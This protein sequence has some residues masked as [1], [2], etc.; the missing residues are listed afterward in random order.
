MK[1]TIADMKVDDLPEVIELWNATE[2]V[3]LN[4]SDTP[5]RLA[6]YLSRNPQQSFIARDSKT[7]RIV[8]AVLCG[9][10]GRRGYLHHLAVAA[11]S[12]GRGIGSELVRKCFA[13]LAAAGITRCNLYVY[14]S[15]ND[16]REFWEKLGW[17]EREDLAVMQIAVNVGL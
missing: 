9:N 13:A 3:G 11:D 8:G 10:D 2:G 5:E 17:A 16:G 6:Q 15:N 14:R 4:E 7:G 1:T 12:R